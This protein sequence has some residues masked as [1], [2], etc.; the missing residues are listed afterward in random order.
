M[1]IKRFIRDLLSRPISYWFGAVP[2]VEYSIRGDVLLQ[3]SAGREHQVCSARDIEYWS[4]DKTAGLVT[5]GLTD[6]RRL[7]I[8]DGRRRLAACLAA[9]PALVRRRD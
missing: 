4:D 5:L 3:G 7:V 9:D 8:K 2:S 6:G 1:K